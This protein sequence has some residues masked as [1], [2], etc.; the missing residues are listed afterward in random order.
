MSIARPGVWCSGDAGI[1]HGR[2]RCEG[3]DA[4]IVVDAEVLAVLRVAVMA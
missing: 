4:L 2:A 1:T 3:S